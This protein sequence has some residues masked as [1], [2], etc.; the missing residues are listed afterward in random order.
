MWGG[1]DLKAG[2]ATGFTPTQRILVLERAT[3]PVKR[4]RERADNPRERLV[5]MQG[6]KEESMKIRVLSVLAGIQMILATAA[7]VSAGVAPYVRL[8]YGGNGLRMTG[9][10]ADIRESETLLREVGWP[11][12]FQ[13]IGTGYGPGVSAGLWILPGVRV[14][15]T[16]SYLRACRNNG[17]DVPDELFYTD[18]L[19]FRMN[20]IG[21]EAAVRF[22]RWAGFTV[23]ANVAASRGE[24]VERYFAETPDVQVAV[25]ATARRTKMTYGAFVGIDQTNP[26]GV[27]GFVQVGYRYRDLGHMEGRWSGHLTTAEGTVTDEG[28]DT[29]PEVDFSGFYFRVGIGYD[30]VH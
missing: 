15:A 13:D 20:E 4:T 17:L 6:T 14:G 21:A 24:R 12:T 26:A 16:Y 25:D 7:P 11:V 22:T 9:Q 29:T 3:I 1:P 28:P 27:A 19:D 5:L 30:L 18:A 10:N 2:D 8:D 23:G